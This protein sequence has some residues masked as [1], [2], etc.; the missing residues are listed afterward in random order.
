VTA[1]D[2]VTSTDVPAASGEPEV[3]DVSEDLA[4]GTVF[5][6]ATEPGAEDLASGAPA[7]ADDEDGAE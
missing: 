3:V 4:A 6:D 7:D 5:P 2:G 1:S